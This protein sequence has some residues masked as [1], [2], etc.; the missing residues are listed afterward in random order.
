MTNMQDRAPFSVRQC[1]ARMEL[2][3]ENARKS[4]ARQGRRAPSG[5]RDG[6]TGAHAPVGSAFCEHSPGVATGAING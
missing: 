6:P 2:P 4:V 1:L 3:R 5:S